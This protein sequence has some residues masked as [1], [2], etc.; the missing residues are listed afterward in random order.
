MHSNLRSDQFIDYNYRLGLTWTP[1]NLELNQ[2]N[3]LI[4]S[5]LHD[6]DREL[7]ISVP[8]LTVIPNLIDLALRMQSI[9]HWNL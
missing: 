7:R 5:Y 8:T 4:S 6:F 9:E 1:E 2:Y 3:D